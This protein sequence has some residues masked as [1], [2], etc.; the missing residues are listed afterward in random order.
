MRTPA[1]DYSIGALGGVWWMWAW[2]GPEAPAL[3]MVVV[4]GISV[5]AACVAAH[6]LLAG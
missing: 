3:T 6:V 2:F 5:L 4:L 1:P